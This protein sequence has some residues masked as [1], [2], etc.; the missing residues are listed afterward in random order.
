MAV[1]WRGRQQWIITFHSTLVPLPR[2]FWISQEYHSHTSQIGNNLSTFN[3]I[4]SSTQ[5]QYNLGT[6]HHLPCHL[7]T[8]GYGEEACRWHSPTQGDKRALLAVVCWDHAVALP[9]ISKP[10]SYR[11]ECEQGET[12]V[13]GHFINM[14]GCRKGG[15]LSCWS[16]L[17]IHS[18]S[19][20]H[21]NLWMAR[22]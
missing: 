10:G 20:N 3:H 4:P 15:M 19:L 9:S 5:A 2:I 17:I 18:K 7:N 13:D 12:P 14:A 22:V 1:K 6:V 16:L 21:F 11:E 8:P